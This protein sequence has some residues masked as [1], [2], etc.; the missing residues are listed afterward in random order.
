MLIALIEV[1]LDELGP[2]TVAMLLSGIVIGLLMANAGG[3]FML[4]AD[5]TW[6]QL[7]D[8]NQE[9]NFATAFS[10]LLLLA[11]ALLL[12]QISRLRRMDRF[13][14]YWR[15]LSLL[16]VGMAADEWWLLHERLNE[17]LDARFSTTG[18]FYYDWVIPGSLFV[19]MTWRIY[20]RFL[21]RLSPPTR[22][23]IWLA[24]RLYVAG[25]LGMEMISGYYIDRYGLDNRA[26][27]ALLNGMEESA[28]MF[29]L[30]AFIYAL[31]MHIKWLRHTAYREEVYAEQPD[32]ERQQSAQSKQQ[33]TGAKQQA[34]G[35]KHRVK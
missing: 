7:L 27:L 3:Y 29:G 24:G 33:A 35:A 18:L 14:S 16:F 2:K 12:W 5:S 6:S 30:V 1:L 4:P 8:V 26:I 34:T 17:F 31:L 15:S 21:R 32:S 11:C 23:R 28:E 19:L 25:A 20:A 13:V 9:E 22:R 10:V